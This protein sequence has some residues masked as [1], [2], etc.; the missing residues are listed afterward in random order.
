MVL[1]KNFRICR[2]RQFGD[3]SGA[4]AQKLTEVSSSLNGTSSR[5]LPLGFPRGEA[6]RLD[7]TSEPA[8]LADEGWRWLK[9]S[10]AV[11]CFVETKANAIHLTAY[12]YQPVAT[13]HQSFL[14]IGSEVPLAKKSSF[15]PGEAKG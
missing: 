10:T 13:P 2:G 4:A 9:V 8:R 11:R 14:P 12:I 1:A 7:G 3:P 5:N 15:P 6:A